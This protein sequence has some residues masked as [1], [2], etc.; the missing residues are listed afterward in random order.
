MNRSLFLVTLLMAVPPLSAQEPPP[1]AHQ[2]RVSGY[3][4][5]VASGEVLRGALVRVGAD[6]QVRQTNEE[7]F[8][9]LVLPVGPQDDQMLVEVR[10]QGEQL[11]TTDVCPCRFVKL[12]GQEGW[13]KA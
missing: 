9:A 3:V 5:S 2:E 13:E 4:R 7:G 8:Y 10:R 1:S 11:K 6:A 12:I